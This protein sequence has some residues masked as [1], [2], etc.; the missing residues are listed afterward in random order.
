MD[1]NEIRPHSSIGQKAPVEPTPE[2]RH[3]GPEA[4]EPGFSR[5]RWSYIGAGP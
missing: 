5:N 3:A 4:N 1:Y 2:G